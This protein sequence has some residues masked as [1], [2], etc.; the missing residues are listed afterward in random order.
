MADEQFALRLIQQL[1]VGACLLTTDYKVL[2][3]NDFFADR[4]Q[5]PATEVLGRN[6]LELFPEQA[7]FLK[8]KL[9]SVTLL[10]NISFT[11]W[12]QRPHIFQLKSSRPVTG[13][14]GLMYQ[15]M[16]IVPIF[17]DDHQIQHLFLAIT[18]ATAAAAYST[19][20]K[21]AL[22]KLEEQHSAQAKLINQL[23]EAH[24]QLLQA[25]KMAAIGQLAAGVAHE[26]NNPIGF[27][28]SNLETLQHYCRQLLDTLA[29]TDQLL[30][31]VPQLAQIKSH[32]MQ[33]HNINFLLQDM[34]D[35]I[36]ESLEGAGR[37]MSIVKSLKE[38]SHVDSSD[39]KETNLIDGMESTLRIVNNELKY[40]TQ[41][42]KDY[43]P[44]MPQVFCQSM[45]IN[46]V[47]MN[48][49]LNAAQAIT[50]TGTIYIS[51]GST[52][53]FAEI[54]IRDT[55]TGIPPAH[56][57]KIFEPFFTTKAVGVGTGLGLSLSYSIISKHKGQLSVSSEP[58]KGAEFLIRLPL[59]QP[60]VA[61]D[62][63]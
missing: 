2:L 51:I 32:Y 52:Q 15:N 53:D 35:L 12:E 4:L 57:T 54:R 13:D 55:G 30:E 37:V 63:S 16:Q 24:N 19:A 10:K 21:D 62:A 26:I 41:V 25:E 56:L 46:Q 8:R 27:I 38:F 45:Q 43:Q 44:D 33:K 1:P 17:S 61:E 22:Q 39:W 34:P 40:K 48:L 20:L 42:V 28:S 59:Q 5:L 47:F 23:E 31:K 6:L 14:E 58:G 11:Y 50:D 49:L 36:K 18:D 3:W 9:D 60:V 7:S 29:F